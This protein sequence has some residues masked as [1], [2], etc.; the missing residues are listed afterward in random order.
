MMSRKR[1]FSRIGGAMRRSRLSYRATYKVGGSPADQQ[2]CRERVLEVLRGL[3]V[4]PAQPPEIPPDLPPADAPSPPAPATITPVLR[5]HV[6]PTGL[7][8]PC[9]ARLPRSPS[10][11]ET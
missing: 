1:P 7:L 3:A 11:Q 10:T 5:R 4:P 8:H 6:W 9:V 2:R